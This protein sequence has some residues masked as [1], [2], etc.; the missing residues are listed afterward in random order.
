MAGPRLSERLESIVRPY[1][2]RE[3]RVDLR[4]RVIH[5]LGISGSDYF[6]LIEDVERE[7]E[8]DLTDFLVGPTPEYLPRGLLAW[9]LRMPRKPI[10]SD[11]SLEEIRGFLKAR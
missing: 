4:A 3:A 5:D 9:L 2:G 6:D 1:L 11:V 8:V 7:F 10:Y